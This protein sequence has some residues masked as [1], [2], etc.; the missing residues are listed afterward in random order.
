MFLLQK[1]RG[2]WD[3][4]KNCA[5]E[6]M[7]FKTR[8]EFGR[9]SGSAC[10]SARKYGWMDEI[11]GHM[12]ELKS[13]N[14]YW[15]KERCAAEAKKFKTR[16]DF[17]TKSPRAYGASLE[18]GWMDE[19]CRHMKEIR[20]P[21]GYWSKENCHV[22]AKKYETR[23]EFQKFSHRAYDA[24]HRYGWMD[25]ICGHMKAQGNLFKRCIYV[26]EFENKSVYV[27]LT[28][29]FEKRKR[30]H[31]ENSKNH[32]NRNLRKNFKQKI[33]FKYFKKTEYLDK[34][35]A[36]ELE[37]KVLNSYLI[38]G[39]KKL[40]IAK[41]GGLGGNVIVWNE[42]NS[43]AEA[44]KFKTKVEFRQKSNGAYASALRN[45]WLN[46]I[47][48]HMIP[49]QNPRGYWSK[50][51]CLKEAKKFKT[52]NKFR[53]NNPNAYQAA[54]RNG[55]IDEICRHMKRELHPPGY[56][57]KKR[58]NDEAFKFLTRTAFARGAPSAYSASQANGWLDEICGHMKNFSRP[59]GFW[60]V[61]KNC[62]AEAKKFKTRSEFA[63]G[64][65]SALGGA[66]RNGWVDEICSHMKEIR[67]PD[68]YWTKEKCAMEAKKYKTR[69]K[70]QK[71]S[72]GAYDAA[73][74]NGWMEEI[75]RHMISTQK[76]SG[77]WTKR[78]CFNE[79]QKLK[80][81]KLF[82]KES[83]SAYQSAHRNGWMDQ[84]FPKNKRV[85]RKGN[86]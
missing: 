51:K 30:Q 85:K 82:R 50:D 6:A 83:P 48:S 62:V 26:I 73:R 55:W 68:G 21:N 12:E 40:N 54:H 78:M 43:A 37:E 81:I 5:A 39:F 19:I 79:V 49:L 84:F 27:G 31:L 35:K 75:C 2:Y 60:N 9:N 28:D 7:K 1:P 8:T 41:T 17:K 44:K 72:N 61:K 34:E 56:W 67:K 15:T 53:K 20:K 80:T 86:P 10:N 74:K 52:R 36:K 3:L 63:K 47:C 38:R 58:C 57:T 42:E 65:P 13:P 77:Y 22:E 66:L 45:G 69:S 23:L 76:P 18:S 70:F 11:C 33:K 4:K 64:A 24:A 46:K 16:K 32:V 25:E 71:G 14:G 59:R 29:N